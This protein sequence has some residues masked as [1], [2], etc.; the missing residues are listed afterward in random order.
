[1]TLEEKYK[2]A[3][4]EYRVV[5]EESSGLGCCNP[6]SAFLNREIKR[7]GAI[8]IKAKTEYK[9]SLEEVKF[10]AKKTRKAKK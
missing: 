7:L 8:L 5:V 6:K 9:S 4:S 1:M 2:V 10:V 3:Q